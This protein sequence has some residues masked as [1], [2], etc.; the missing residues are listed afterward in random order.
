[1]RR[2]PDIITLLRMAGSFGLLFYDVT[3]VVFWIIYSLCGVSDIADGWLARKLKCVTRTGALL[4]SLADFCF[5]VCFAWKLLPF[6]Q[7]LVIKL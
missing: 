7:W 1:M 4:D 2:L 5:V 3:S 6:F